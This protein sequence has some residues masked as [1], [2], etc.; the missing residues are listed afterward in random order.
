MLNKFSSY[1]NRLSGDA[2]QKQFILAVSGGKDSMVMLDLCLKMGLKVIVAHVDHLTRNGQSTMDAEFVES[3]CQEKS[4]SYVKKDFKHIGGNFQEQARSFR[5]QFLNE[6]LKE[7]ASDY[8]LTAHH[9]DDNIESTLMALAKGEGLT[10]IQGIQ[11]SNGVLLRPLL[12]ATS[13]MI[14]AYASNEKVLFVQDE[15]NF[16]NDYTRN[17][18]RNLVLPAFIEA[19]P[20]FEK[21]IQK[22]I[23]LLNSDHQLFIELIDQLGASAMYIQKELKVIDITKLEAVSKVESILFHLIR[24][25]GFTYDQ[26]QNMITSKTGSVFFTQNH[27]ALKDRSNLLIR[28]KEESGI[29]QSQDCESSG[30]YEFRDCEISV[31][32][33]NALES[34]S[35]RIRSRLPGDQVLLSN[36]MKKSVKKYLIDKKINRWDKENVLVLE[37]NGEAIDLLYPQS[38]ATDN[39]RKIGVEIVY[40]NP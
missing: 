23:S 33:P 6:L 34:N 35:L 4:I 39:Y 17:R 8:I 22:S 20:Q 29:F 10:G 7:T 18:I 11:E 9:F 14:A 28:K 30:K 21:G 38:L 12:F 13:K 19:V 37:S 15:S 32:L 25:E 40:L 3:Y 27:E 2:Q 26:C 5:Y 31:L 36:G 1:I 24:E 16:S